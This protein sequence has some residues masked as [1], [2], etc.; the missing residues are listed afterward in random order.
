MFGEPY[1][2]DDDFEL[3]AADYGAAI[4]YAGMNVDAS[5]YTAPTPGVILA[6]PRVD[7]PDPDRFIRSKD[8]PHARAV[9]VTRPELISWRYWRH[10]LGMYRAMV[11]AGMGVVEARREVAV[12]VEVLAWQLEKQAKVARDSQRA[13]GIRSV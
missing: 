11:T 12:E 2:P 9:T 7:G 3:Y 13:K 5:V 4:A 6:P 10:F 1:V 8:V